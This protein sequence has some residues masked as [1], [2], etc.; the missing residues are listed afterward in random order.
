MISLNKATKEDFQNVK[1]VGAKTAQNII[2]VGPKTVDLM[3]EAFTL[4]VDA[5]KVI[6]EIMEETN[7]E[8]KEEDKENIEE[9]FEESKEKK[10]VVIE[11]KPEE[12]GVF[13]KDEAHLVGDMNDWNPEDKS[14]PLKYEGKGIWNNVFELEPG[15]KYKVMYDSTSWDNNKYIGNGYNNFVV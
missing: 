10:A 11:L 5:G 8:V 4:E 14:F 12:H 2:G 6:E 15:S 1:G 7:Q 9:V 13:I 3:K